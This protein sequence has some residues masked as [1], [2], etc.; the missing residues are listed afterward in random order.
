MKRAIDEPDAFLK[1]LKEENV[2]LE[3]DKKL[4]RF[5]L[6]YLMHRTQ[7]LRAIYE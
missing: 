4:A 3:K 2:Q 7:V 5:M 6:A 1:E